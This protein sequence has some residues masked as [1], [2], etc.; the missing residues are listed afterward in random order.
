M[1]GEAPVSANAF[2]VIILAAGQGRRFG[3]KLAK[4]FVP[5]G[6]TADTCPMCLTVRFYTAFPGIR[7][8]YLVLPEASRPCYDCCFKCSLGKVCFVTGG[9]TRQE[10]SHNAVRE[11]YKDGFRW[12][13]IHEAVRPF[14]DAKA[15]RAVMRKLRQGAWSV[16]STYLPPS[17]V[18]ELQ[19][20]QV[21]R[22]MD[23]E[24]VALGQHPTGFLVSKL[25]QAHALSMWDKQRVFASDCA[26]MLDTF[27]RKI[28]IVPGSPEG[29]KITHPEDLDLARYFYTR[30]HR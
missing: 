12:V 8:V 17:A 11:A 18:F 29:F 4:Q 27:D 10:S 7:R 14:V 13:I 6:D 23:R 25:R 1:E 3:S 24:R 15:V 21:V 26:L 20:G 9:R 16:V 28:E 30:R 19:A 5:L 22:L 2:A